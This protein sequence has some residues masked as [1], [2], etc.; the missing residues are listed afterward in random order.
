L[1][2]AGVA[3]LLLIGGFVILNFRREA[4]ERAATRK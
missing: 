3:T 1:R 4:R 2:V